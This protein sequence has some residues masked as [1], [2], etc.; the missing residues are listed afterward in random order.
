MAK[1]IVYK[2][3]YLG[4]G[5]VWEPKKDVPSCD[6]PRGGAWGLRSEDFRMGLPAVRHS[7]RRGNP[8]N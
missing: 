7:E 4:N 2:L 6:K 3:N 8:G 5:L 1:W